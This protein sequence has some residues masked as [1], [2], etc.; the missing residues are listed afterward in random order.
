LPPLHPA[1]TLK[2]RDPLMFLMMKKLYGF[3]AFD[4]RSTKEI[5]EEKRWMQM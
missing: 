2:D 5:E 3:N 1:C 4:V